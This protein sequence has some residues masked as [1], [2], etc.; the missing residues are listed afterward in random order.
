[1]HLLGG[2]TLRDR[3]APAEPPRSQS[4]LLGIGGIAVGAAVGAGLMFLLD[5][6]NGCR[7]RAAV[8][9]L[10]ARWGEPDT[11]AVAGSGPSIEIG[12]AHV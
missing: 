4:L 11:E 3:F 12:R 1:M 6:V 7:R 10:L 8:R 9:R 5:P 2:M